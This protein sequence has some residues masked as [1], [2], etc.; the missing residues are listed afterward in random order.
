MD[1]NFNNFDDMMRDFIDRAAI[2]YIV[3]LAPD[4]ES[5]DVLKKCLT[6]FTK[7]GIKLND[8]IAIMTDLSTALT[9]SKVNVSNVSID[10]QKMA[11]SILHNAYSETKATKDELIGYMCKARSVL[12]PKNRKEKDALETL[13]IALYRS[14]VTKKELRDAIKRAAEDLCK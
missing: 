9:P 14:K 7:H 12:N 5:R 6:V 13:D 11:Y 2:D 8:A 4:A 1:F 10:S 3:S